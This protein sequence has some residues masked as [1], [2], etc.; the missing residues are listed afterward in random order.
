VR[1]DAFTLFGFVEVLAKGEPVKDLTLWQVGLIVKVPKQVV[2]R[3][4]LAHHHDDVIE[5]WRVPGAQ[6][7]LAIL[8]LMKALT[9]AATD[10]AANYRTRRATSDGRTERAGDPEPKEAA[11]RLGGFTLARRICCV[12]R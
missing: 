7:C 2:E 5:P 4:V 8:A 10:G 1:I 3:S 11:S 9:V 6:L 12:A